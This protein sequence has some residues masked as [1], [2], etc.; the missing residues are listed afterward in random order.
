MKKKLFESICFC[1]KKH[2]QKFG[3]RMFSVGDIVKITNVIEIDDQM[4]NEDKKS[5]IGTLVIINSVIPDIQATTPPY[6]GQIY[7]MNGTPRAFHADELQLVGKVAEKPLPEIGDVVYVAG[8]KRFG[9]VKQVSVKVKYTEFD[10][11]NAAELNGDYVDIVPRQVV[12]QLEKETLMKKQGE[13][14]LKAKETMD[15]VSKVAFQLNQLEIKN[16]EETK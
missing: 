13:L 16:K 9:R 3:S 6:P 5:L 8:S 10:S 14:M 4:R 11:N 1:T 7:R 15:E 2:K 12:F